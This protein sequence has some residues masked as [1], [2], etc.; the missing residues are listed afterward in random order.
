ME[1]ERIEKP[2][3]T[4]GGGFS[5]KRLRAM[6]LG[7]DKRRKGQDEDADEDYDAV[8]KASVRSD[9]DARGGS[10][11][12]EEYKDVDVVSTISESSSSVETGSGHR[13]RDT[14][15]IGSRT[16]APEED[17]C[18]SESVASNFEFHK[19]RGA[20][21]RSPTANR[22]C[23]ATSGALPRKVEKPI[24][25]A[26]RLPATK[27]VLEATE[28]ID[29]KRIDPSQEKR[30]IGW[31]KAV[32]WA[33]PDP[34]P[35]V[36]PCSKSAL[37]E[38]ETI[39]DSA[40]NSSTLQSATACIPPPSTVR[41]VSMRDMGT[42]MTPIASQEPSRTGTPVRATSPYYSR[43]TTPRR[44]SGPNAIGSVISHGECSNAEL[45]EQ[46]L[47][48]KTRRE[49][50]LLGTQLGKTN[51]AAWAS[52]KEEKDASLL[53]K[54]LPMDQSTQN[55]TE[56]RAA[57]WE[58]AEKAKYLARFKREEIK[59]QA[60][61]DHQ[62]AKIEAEMRKIE[63]EVER[64]RA[65]AQDKLMTHLASA[66]HTADEKRADAES[67]RNR[68]AA[69]TAEQAEYIRRTGRV[70]PSFGCWNWCS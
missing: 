40:V 54:T 52:K 15:S 3:P 36:E 49:I 64:M 16:R 24:S 30:E 31:Q 10:T 44:T 45:S 13:S 28:E 7:V 35:E 41:S 4:Q 66:R 18:D 25:G 62:K 60:W 56:I 69:R 2:F 32:S 5:P 20:S 8:P 42:E 53:L 21:A 38:E 17:S 1:Y 33:P 12:C 23:R 61:E 37:V 55:L 9:A 22:P 50:M 68:A 27:V 70:P 48:T 29:T 34:C 39:T 26:G 46:E 14:H 11:M 63:V 59:I 43:P 51:I 67:K 57:A 65:R 6:L 19:E 47:Q 58:E